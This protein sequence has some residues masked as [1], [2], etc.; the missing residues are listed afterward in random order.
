LKKGIIAARFESYYPK[1]R[2]ENGQ[3]AFEKDNDNGYCDVA[4]TKK[5]IYCL[6]SGRSVDEYGG[7]ALKAN[8]IFVFDWELNPVTSYLLD[9]DVQAI[10][11]SEDDS[12]LYSSSIIDDE[13]E[14]IKFEMIKRL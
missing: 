12:Y 6:F 1:F 11:V 5:Y 2:V 10:A 3:A 8:N 4:V 7:Q 14:L 9:C 13:F